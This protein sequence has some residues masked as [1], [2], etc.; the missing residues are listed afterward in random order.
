MSRALLTTVVEHLPSPAAAQALR[1]PKLLPPELL[2]ATMALDTSVVPV[3]PSIHS[4]PLPPAVIV[5]IQKLLS[6]IYK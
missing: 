3:Q 4:L 1:V 2:A 5:E 6:A